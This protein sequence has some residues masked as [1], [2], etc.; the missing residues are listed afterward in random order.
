MIRPAYLGG[1]TGYKGVCA[2]MKYN[3]V[4]RSVGDTQAQNTVRDRVIMG[5]MSFPW[6]GS[7]PSI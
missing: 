4:V 5:D 2:L 6:D 7:V 3:S 1:V